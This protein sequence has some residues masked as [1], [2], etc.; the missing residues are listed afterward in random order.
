MSNNITTNALYT[1]LNSN[2]HKEIEKLIETLKQATNH[3]ST[4]KS[5]EELISSQCE[6]IE[7]GDTNQST[8]NDLYFATV[9]PSSQGKEKAAINLAFNYIALAQICSEAGSTTKAWSAASNA[10][11]HLGLLNG[12][13]T[14]SIGKIEKETDRAIERASAGGTKKIENQ[15]TMKALIA[16]ELCTTNNPSILTT[17]RTAAEWLSQKLNK[18]LQKAGILK[19]KTPHEIS[20]IFEQVIDSDLIIGSVFLARKD[21]SS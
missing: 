15:E 9:K 19:N 10:H 16:K 7:S 17:S 20:D 21:A 6:K 2:I 1:A 11:Y 12:L 8:M 3:L 18:E 14:K 13:H 5:I 4:E